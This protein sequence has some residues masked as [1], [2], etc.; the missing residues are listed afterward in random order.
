MTTL[1]S[2]HQ[3]QEPSHMRYLSG[4]TTFLQWSFEN[5][6]ANGTRGFLS[7][8]FFSASTSFKISKS[9]RWALSIFTSKSWGIVRWYHAVSQ[10]CAALGFRHAY[11]TL[12]ATRHCVLKLWMCCWLCDVRVAHVSNKSTQHWKEFVGLQEGR[13]TCDFCK[14]KATA[15]VLWC[16]SKVRICTK[17]CIDSLALVVKL[18][19]KLKQKPRSFCCAVP[20]PRD[21]SVVNPGASA[22]S[23]DVWTRKWT[24]LHFDV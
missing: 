12:Q 20:S 4:L 22:V 13:L 8:M 16:A 7:S 9:K 17:L 11:N 15:E 24:R 1:G 10:K 5:Q 23:S 21:F 2:F 3:V 18:L 14:G 19:W 6:T